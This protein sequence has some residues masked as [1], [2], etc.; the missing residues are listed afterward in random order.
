MT[1]FPLYDILS[2]TIQE[3]SHVDLKASDKTKLIKCIQTLDQDGRNKIY[4]LIRYHALNH[5]NELSENIE[6]IPYGGYAINDELI[7]D[8]DR[9]PLKLQHILL[10][11]T[12]IHAKHM[13]D[14]QKIEKMRKKS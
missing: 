2:S 8:V 7:F 5:V 10:E 11:F 13:K 9:L 12:K 3:Q 1:S 6:I 4:A 14:N